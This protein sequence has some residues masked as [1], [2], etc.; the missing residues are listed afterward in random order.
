[1][2]TAA[3]L[4]AGWAEPKLSEVRTGG[5]EEGADAPGAW[6]PPGGAAASVRAGALLES[7]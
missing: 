3:P 5:A 2:G 4:P 7:T 6:P 1:V